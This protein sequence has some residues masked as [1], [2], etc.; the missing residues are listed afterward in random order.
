MSVTIGIDVAKDKLDIYCDG[1]FSQCLNSTAAIKKH[2]KNFNQHDFVVMEATSK[3]HRR[4]H[5]LMEQMGFSVMVVNPYQSKH[6]GKAQNLICKTDRVDA[7]LLADFASKIDCKPTP[8]LTKQQ[9]RLLELSRHLA[10]SKAEKL[11]LAARLE[12]SDR[13]VVCSLKRLLK[14]IKKEIEACELRLRKIVLADERLLKQFELLQTIPGVGET[15]AIAL[16]SYLRE[17]GKVNKAEIAALV[18]VAPINQDS[19]K[20]SGKRRIRG[21][22][23]ELRRQLYLPVVGSAT[24][25]NPRLK[26]F[27]NRL[28]ESGKPKKVAL[29]ACMRKLVVWANTMLANECA[30]AENH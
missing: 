24:R 22:R 26:A 9:L 20:L 1:K 25:H 8:S 30:W 17:L 4:S 10:D 27:Y 21:G 18:G 2:F 12:E 7:K 6:F 19:G 14:H 29:T 13:F 15:T 28:V 11:A 16:L 3:Y 23:F 5:R